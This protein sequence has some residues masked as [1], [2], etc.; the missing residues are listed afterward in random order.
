MNNRTNEQIFELVNGHK[1]STFKIY[2]FLNP[3]K[4]FMINENYQQ[5]FFS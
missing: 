4:E 5:K 1:S 3:T 2:M